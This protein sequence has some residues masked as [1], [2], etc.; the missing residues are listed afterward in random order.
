MLD[1]YAR[2][3]W[4]CLGI[5]CRQISSQARS[6]DLSSPLNFINGSRES[7]DTSE[8]TFDL[9]EPS[10]GDKLTSV[11]IS[12]TND[13]NKAVSSAKSA[14]ND[15]KSKT[16]VERA[17]VLRIAGRFLRER[18]NDIAKMEVVDSGKP[19]WEALWDIQ[20]AYDSFEYFAGLAPTMSG[21]HIKLGNGNW[22]YTIRQPIGVVGA[23]GAW[24][25][26]IQISSWKIAPS[27][28]FGNTVVFKP[29]PLTPLT[30]V[31]L[32]EILIE[33]GLPKG[34]VNVVQ[35]E[36]KTGSL[37]CQHPDVGKIT[38][39]GSV[40]TG[41]LIARDASESL[42]RVTLELGGKSPLIIFD[43]CNLQNAVNG[44]LMANF[45]SQG[46]VCSNATR[47][48]VHES[49]YDQFL[50]QVVAAAESIKVGD[51]HD[52]VN[53]M[54]ALISQSHLQKVLSYVDSAKQEGA[55]VFG[56]EKLDKGGGF[57]MQPCILADCTDQMKAVQ[58]EIFGPVMCILK[59]ASEEEVIQRANGTDFGLAGGVFTQNL[60][61]A[62]RVIDALEG[63]VLWINN[64]NT[65]TVEMPFGGLKQSGYGRE[66]GSA[67]IEHF[68]EL[69]TVFVES[70]GVWT[71]YS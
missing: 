38:F 11:G 46:Q 37:L 62:H 22:A 26:P 69:K 23:I 63:G 7:P 68:T 16:G 31:V 10:S 5:F 3:L 27:L 64:Y 59:F 33:A 15:W 17:H 65:F 66:N 50:N 54:G 13:V 61:R 56:G 35:G 9:I 29:S 51:P 19:M 47:V 34:A 6:L 57:Y 60:A 41:K 21:Q 48:F 71:P 45:L 52:D 43:D 49:I 44:A 20:T 36:A 28:A 32:C 14:F 55:L 58:E 8:G 53:R 70:G 4:G 39:T 25:Y 30:A 67:A 2:P 12:G 1:V 18:A 40:P 42:K 24:N